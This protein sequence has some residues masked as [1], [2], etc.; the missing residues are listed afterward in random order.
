MHKYLCS[1]G[2]NV[3]L[4]RRWLLSVVSQVGV[5]D[6]HTTSYVATA[7]TSNTETDVYTILLCVLHTVPYLLLIVAIAC[8]IELLYN[9]AL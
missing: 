3:R 2:I 5:N 6:I 1:Y 9:I 7:V 4:C 8:L